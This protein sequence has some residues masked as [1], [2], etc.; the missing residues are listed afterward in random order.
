[1]KI[2][3][4]EKAREVLS[5]VPGVVVGVG[6]TAWTRSGV[7]GL[8]SRYEVIC[9]K[10]S[11]ELDQL[12]R[13]FP[14]KIGRGVKMNTS[15]ILSDKEIQ[16]YLKSLPR[17][18][19]PRG[20]PEPKWLFVYKSSRPTE[21]IAADLGMKL[22][23]NRAEIRDPYEDKKQ[24]RILG[25]EAGLRLVE[26]ETMR[27]NELTNRK[28]GVVLQLTDYSRGGGVGTFFI[29]TPDNWREFDEFVR[30]R[31][32]KRKLEWV[33]VTRLVE[34]LAAS[35]NGCVTK[36]G[37]LTG[38]LQGQIVDQPELTALSGRSGVWLGHDWSSMRFSDKAQRN[39]ESLVRTL[40]KHMAKRG[41]KGIFGMDVV[42]EQQ[43]KV[44]PIECNS[45]YTGAF[46][47]YT[48][49]SIKN[50]EIPLDVWHLLE[51]MEVD[52]DMDFDKVQEMSRQPKEGAQILMHNLEADPS[53][54]RASA[55]RGSSVRVKG[56]VKA[57]IYRWQ[58]IGDRCRIEYTREG[59][60]LLHL[61]NKD[62][63]ILTD[64]VP[65]Q[66]QA[67]KPAERLGRL[68]FNR[69]IVDATGRLLP[70]IQEVVKKL[71]R[72][73]GLKKISKKERLDTNHNL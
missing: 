70:E 38:V 12:R 19:A 54:R 27:I 28:L 6:V 44:W 15:S 39:A 17:K 26:G 14:V 71:Y 47:T 22:I 60:N 57:G 8:V 1:M 62:E 13:E 10:E 34:G 56:V 65:R 23:G 42:V 72:E 73:F 37:I 52:Y 20:E 33:N 24:F 43:D 55:R 45:R 50:G 11:Q 67:L 68:L 35:I 29:K 3:S 58:M 9:F 32:Q 36:H 46:P 16:K 69:A 2:D 63:F 59:W 49:V 51:F 5:R 61:K 7:A 48:W 30:R 25:K 41:Y 64:G 21:K 18:A 53:S 4:L 66:G 40:G 31:G